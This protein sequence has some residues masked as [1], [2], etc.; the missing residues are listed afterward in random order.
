VHWFGAAAALITL[1]KLVPL[2]C[3]QMI[4]YACFAALLPLLQ[5]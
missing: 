3:L 1:M 4:M 5:W 2:L